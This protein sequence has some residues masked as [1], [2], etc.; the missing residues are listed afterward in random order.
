MRIQ[1]KTSK[2]PLIVAVV[3]VA[4]LACVSVSTYLWIHRN[5]SQDNSNQAAEYQ[6]KK[7]P[8]QHNNS[9]DTTHSNNTSGDTNSQSTH[10][11]EKDITPAYEGDNPN[12]ASD[13]S[14]SIN[15]SAV[16]GTTLI[17]RTTI[18]QTLSSG[19]CQ[20]TLTN[21]SKTITRSS[22]IAQNPS[23]ST[24][25]G[26]DIPTSELSGGTWSITIKITGDS[27]SG[28]LSGSATI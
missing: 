27:K 8:S 15:Y 23:S 1:K 5:S 21:G 3:I 16:A 22:Q 14:G 24:C 17:I 19:A 18:N 2:K 13:L 26:F 12:Q 10:E 4:L 9:T 11:K 25:E 6:Q 20:L 28:S 7:Q